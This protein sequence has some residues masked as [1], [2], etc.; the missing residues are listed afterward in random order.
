MFN[1]AKNFVSWEIFGDSLKLA[2]DSTLVDALGPKDSVKMKPKSNVSIA[3]RTK[4][5]WCVSIKRCGH[6]HRLNKVLICLPVSFGPSFCLAGSIT[7]SGVIYLVL[8]AIS[9]NIDNTLYSAILL[10]V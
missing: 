2:W 6:N 7:G 4:R 1:I 8:V 5:T 3:I 9:W 10:A